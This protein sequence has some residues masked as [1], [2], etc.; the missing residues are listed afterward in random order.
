MTEVGEGDRDLTVA[1]PILAAHSRSLIG[2]F[3]SA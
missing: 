1:L 2:Y 3:C